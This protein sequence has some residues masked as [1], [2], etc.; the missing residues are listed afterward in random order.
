M[1]KVKSKL[2]FFAISFIAL[3]CVNFNCFCQVLDAPKPSY[4]Y[5]SKHTS[6]N[7][8]C[9]CQYGTY[10]DSSEKNIKQKKIPKKVR[11]YLKEMIFINGGCTVVK[12]VDLLY[13]SEK[14]TTL[15]F[16]NHS[17][18]ICTNSFLLGAKEI[19]NKEYREFVYW[20]RDSIARCILAKNNPNYYLSTTDKRLNWLIPIN[21]NDS[22]LTKFIYLDEQPRFYRRREF[23]SRKIIYKYIDEN[24]SIIKIHIYPDTLK[25]V[26]EFTYSFNEP[27]TQMYFWHPAYDNYPVVAI[28]Y[29]QAMAYCHWKTEQ[30]Q[31]Q[32]K[33]FKD[34]GNTTISYRLP[35]E[36]EWEYAAIGP[37]NSDRKKETLYPWD[38]DIMLNEKGKYYANSG[39]TLNKNGLALRYFADDGFFHTGLVGHYEENDFGIYDMA[40][41]VA[42]WTEDKPHM[43][44]LKDYFDCYPYHDS[45]F[46]GVNTAISDSD[47][48]HSLM[49]KI[50]EIQRKDSIYESGIDTIYQYGR[51]R[52][53][54]DAKNLLHD[55]MVV[56]NTV[57]PRTVKGGSWADPSTYMLVSLNQV[58]AE[59][60]S[61]C[62]IGFRMA[63]TI[64]NELLPYFYSS[65][66]FDTQ[67]KIIQDA[68]KAKKKS[69]RQR[70]RGY[71]H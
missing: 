13:P 47:N 64:P 4:I 19:T 46:S 67:N 68:K 7:D 25:W 5:R 49:K 33:N 53:M 69:L 32:L 43:I 50:V 31:K 70:Y 34:L 56:K 8:I 16:F 28:T 48:F 6:S 24:E 39:T 1:L 11:N 23:D 35:T 57:N 21:W 62:K 37:S 27:M 61:S 30:L 54:N 42:E 45:L 29:N 20:V 58:Y 2:L 60:S 14:D 26:K 22:I 66:Y 71:K 63:M 15:L 59:D 17:K 3:F 44:S 51:N 36:L 9:S 38:S 18:R 40:G 12:N 55:Y 10:S 41:N 65:K 52:I